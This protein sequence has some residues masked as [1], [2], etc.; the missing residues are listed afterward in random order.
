MNT[1]EK[2]IVYNDRKHLVQANNLVYQKQNKQK[3][4][5]KIEN[6]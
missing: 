6:Q 4:Y 3:N 2:E 5:V 1:I